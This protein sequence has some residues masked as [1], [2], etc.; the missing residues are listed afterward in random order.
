MNQN[1]NFLYLFKN[2]QMFFWEESGR[3]VLKGGN[4]LKG[5]LGLVMY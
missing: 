4:M 1:G 2:V 5:S 3:C